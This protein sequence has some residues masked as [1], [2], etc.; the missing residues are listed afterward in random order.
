MS[1]GFE[2]ALGDQNDGEETEIND[3][4]GQDN[5]PD[6]QWQ[7][8]QGHEK[9]KQS[10]WAGKNVRGKKDNELRQTEPPQSPQKLV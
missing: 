10:L 4:V 9:N 8:E 2:F 3:Q 7:D 6:A 1:D 5:G